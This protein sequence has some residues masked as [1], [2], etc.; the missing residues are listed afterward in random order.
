MLGG[1]LNDPR[2][3]GRLE[4]AVLCREKSADEWC[5]TKLSSPYKVLTADVLQNDFYSNCLSWGMESVAI[6]LLSEVLV[7][8]KETTCFMS[9]VAD[10]LK[11]DAAYGIRGEAPSPSS[12]G[13][14]PCAV[15]VTRY[16]ESDV[17]MGLSNGKACL[18]HG[19]ADGGFVCTREFDCPECPLAETVMF[20]S[21]GRDMLSC[22]SAAKRFPAGLC[23]EDAHRYADMMGKYES[24]VRSVSCSATCASL[25]HEIVVGTASSG[26]FLLDTRSCRVALKFGSQGDLHPS[27][28]CLSSVRTMD[29]SAGGSGR[30]A[31]SN[32]STSVLGVERLC[33]V[34]WSANGS[35]VSTGGSNGVAKIWSL[36]APREPLQQIKMDDHSAVKAVAF[37]PQNPYEVVLG[38]SAGV[39]GLRAYD[40]S[41]AAPTLRYAGQTDTPITQLLHSPDGGHVVSAHGSARSAV[42]LKNLQKRLE[43]EAIQPDRLPVTSA[44]R[45]VNVDLEGYTGVLSTSRETRCDEPE[46]TSG[47]FALQPSKPTP[48]YCL[49]V[50]KRKKNCTFFSPDRNDSRSWSDDSRAC[51]RLTAVH[52]LSGH[53]DRPLYLATPFAG[54]ASGGRIASA[55]GGKD[56]SLRFWRVFQPQAAGEAVNTV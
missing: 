14:R 39:C 56:K 15:S 16:S 37:H 4:R 3:A 19:C 27:V 52:I 45:S 28:S 42:S 13:P 1:E 55:S 53:R 21:R 41:S 12:K 31:I 51:S 20:R 25:P 26:L 2:S 46:G 35:Y 10:L 49:A 6:G 38:G 8:Q 44:D 24:A 11:A 22:G 34:S 30:D 50:W 36:S 40:I 7:L 23:K 9:S 32:V 43:K 18:L 17:F 5:P 48:S 47:A 54:S 29:T 33:S